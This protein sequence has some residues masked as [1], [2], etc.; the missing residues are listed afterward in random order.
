MVVCPQNRSVLNLVHGACEAR[1]GKGVR[2][3]RDPSPH[4]AA[5]HRR[6]IES[7]VADRSRDQKRTACG[8]QPAPHERVAVES[9]DEPRRPGPPRPGPRL[10]LFRHLLDI[11]HRG[12]VT[13]FAGVQPLDSLRGRWLQGHVERHVQMHRP[14]G[15]T[16]RVPGGPPHQVD[17]GPRHHALQFPPRRKRQVRLEPHAVAEDTRLHDRLIRVRAAH[18]RRPV[19]GQQDQRHI[20]LVGLDHGRQQVGHRR[21]RCRQHRR[22]T[23]VRAPVPDGE[24]PRRAL[25]QMHACTHSGQRT[26]RKHQGSRARARS[27]LHLLDAVL[28]KRPQDRLRPREVQFPACHAITPTRLP[29]RRLPLRAPSPGAPA[30][31]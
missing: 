17:H 9:P 18:L 8:L 27:D 19:G 28:R 31:T 3:R 11:R 2:Q 29:R 5:H 30:G 6:P 15:R 24:V 13:P 14:A 22:G 1:A 20:G 25:V 10:R 26:G 12:A 23:E 7:R 16:Q 4:G 21:A